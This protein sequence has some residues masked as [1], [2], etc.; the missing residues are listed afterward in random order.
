M[1]YCLHPPF[2]KGRVDGRLIFN[3]VTLS[4]SISLSS[5]LNLILEKH[6]ELKPFIL[7]SVEETFY[8]LLVFRSG[9]ALEKDDSI[10]PDDIVEVMMPLHGG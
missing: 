10:E 4:E 2:G 3:D 9:E 8:R 5:F 1:K 6:P 7:E